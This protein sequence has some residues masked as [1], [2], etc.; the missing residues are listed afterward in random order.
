MVVLLLKCHCNYLSTYFDWGFSLINLFAKFATLSVS[1]HAHAL[2]MYVSQP[3][4]AWSYVFKYCNNF[5]FAICHWFIFWNLKKKPLLDSLVKSINNFVFIPTA[6]HLKIF[7]NYI[8]ELTDLVAVKVWN[9]NFKS[10]KFWINKIT[11]S[12]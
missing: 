7:L 9:Q 1:T 11:K 12:T 2:I 5:F 4:F 8:V 10:W 6:E 3:I